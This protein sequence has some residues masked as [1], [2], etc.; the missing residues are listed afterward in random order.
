MTRE[1]L[2]QALE[3]E[4][5]KPTNQAYTLPESREGTCYVS[6]QGDLLP[7]S[8]IVRIELATSFVRIDTAKDEHLYFAYEDV[9]GFRIL[10][11]P[12]AA[13]RERGAGFAR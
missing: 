7:I 9:L 8:R 12:A 11:A 3:A 10:A 1:M 5:F 4:G 13:T 6:G 2:A